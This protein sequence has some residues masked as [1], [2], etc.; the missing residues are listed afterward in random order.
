MTYQEGLNQ[1]D[2]ATQKIT[3]ANQ[4][5]IDS[6]M[7]AFLFTWQWWIALVMLVVPWII[8]GIFRERE[9]SARIFSAGLLVIVLTEIL[10]T[11]GVSFGKWA[12]PVKVIPVATLNFSFRLSVLPVLVML[13]L[14]WKPRFNPYIKAIF[15]GGFSAYVGLPTLAIIDLYKKIDWNF[16]YSFFILTLLYLLAHWFSRIDTFKN[17][18]NVNR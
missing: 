16:T 18:E 9:S 3:E 10:D 1:I 17:I 7:N 15:F 12:Y 8:W 11:V 14:Q 4:L 13:L 6:I 2:K 5:I